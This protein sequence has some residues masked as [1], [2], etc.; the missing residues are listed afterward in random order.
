M[1][2]RIKNKIRTVSGESIVESLI[3]VLLVGLSSAML[4]NSVQSS[5]NI[6]SAGIKADKDYTNSLASAFS[7]QESAGSGSVY[8]DGEKAADVTFFGSGDLVSFYGTGSALPVDP[9]SPSSP[10]TD[11][12]TVNPDSYP[13]PLP[14]PEPTEDPDVPLDKW[15]ALKETPDLYKN[16][17]STT[18][19]RKKTYGRDFKPGDVIIDGSTCYL[20]VR[21]FT[22]QDVCDSYSWLSSIKYAFHYHT[23]EYQYVT[24]DAV[25]DSTKLKNGYIIKATAYFSEKQYADNKSNKTKSYTSGNV[26]MYK[27]N[28]YVATQSIKYNSTV[29][30]TDSGS[31]WLKLNQ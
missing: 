3:A 20:V 13:T 22:R 16:G 15:E 14:T 24:S 18:F 11:K 21:S 6:N 31:G 10:G 1:L 12:P 27:G 30:P 5:V 4:V 17:K 28:Y 29:L 19:F 8:I 23:P 2:D 25:I 7:K 26:I 9:Y